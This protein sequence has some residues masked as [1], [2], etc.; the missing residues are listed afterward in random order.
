L[1]HL[2]D[3][4]TR[5]AA[6]R[7]RATALV[8]IVGCCIPGLAGAQYSQHNLVSNGFVSADHIDPTLSNPWGMAFS[9]TSF[10]WIAVDQSSISTLYDGAGVR[11]PLVVDTPIFPSGMVFNPSTDFVVSNGTSSAPASFIFCHEEGQISAWKSSIT[12]TSSVIVADRS[13][14][15]A[16]YP[17]MAI[18]TGASGSRLYAA[19]FVRTKGVDM[20]DAAFNYIGSFTDPTIEEFYSPFNVQ[21]IGSSVYVA[22]AWTGVNGDP[23]P[24]DGLGY[25]DEFDATGHLIRRIA[26]NGVLNAPWGMAMAPAGFGQFAGDLLVANFGDGKI[27]AFDPVSGAFKGTLRDTNGNAIVN[28]KIWGITFGNGAHGLDPNSLYFTSAGATEYDGLFGRLDPVPEPMP[29]AA[30]GIGIGALLRRRK[31]ARSRS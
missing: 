23:T 10:M 21:S 7:I 30:F 6:R 18:Q 1:F 3:Q 16:Y 20:F 17:G 5:R 24:G 19:N 26:S 31:Q 15:I 8:A 13:G 12:G 28:D 27:N 29:L 14:S 25:V 9:P 4:I 22:Y 2:G 11:Q